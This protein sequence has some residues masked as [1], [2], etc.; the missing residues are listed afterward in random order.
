MATEVLELE[1]KS[2]IKGATKDMDGSTKSG[3]KA[4]DAEAELNSNIELQIKFLAEQQTELSRLQRIQDSIPKGAFYAGQSKLNESIEEVTK[5]IRDEKEG[6]KK[7]QKEQKAANKVIRDATAAKKK[8]TNQTIRGIQHF[9]IMGVSIRQLKHMVRSIRPAFK[10]MFGTIKSGIAATGI[11]L[12]I[13]AFGSLVVWL[14]KSESGAKV[15]S[16]AFEAVGNVINAVTDAIV[17][18][19]DGIASF[20]GMASD[21][22]SAVKGVNRL[23]EATKTLGKRMD[24]L[25]VKEAKN[26]R[27]RDDYNR[28]ADDTSKSQKTRMDAA[29]KGSAIELQNIDDKIQASKDYAIVLEAERVKVNTQAKQIWQVVALRAKATQI[30]EEQVKKQQE[31]ET[32]LAKLELERYNASLAYADKQEEIRQTAKEARDEKINDEKEIAKQLEEIQNELDFRELETAREVE[33]AKLLIAKEAAEQELEDSTASEE[34]KNAALLLIEEKYQ[35]DLAVIDDKAWEKKIADNDKW[36]KKQIADKEK[37]DAKQKKLD[38]D[39]ETEKQKSIAMGFDA[40]S[41]LAKE[42]SGIA[43]GIAVARTVYNTQQAI[44]NAMATVPAPW[45]LAQSVATGVMGAAAIQ[46]ILSTNPE[47]GGG[48]GGGAPVVATP[49]AP[50]M[51]SGAFE[52]TGG[53]A[54]EPARA[55]VVSDDITANQDKLAIIRRRATI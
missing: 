13:L 36:N 22:S 31:Q 50:E 26:Q 3:G 55:Y 34:T 28:T 35:S 23:E 12:L 53:Q 51:M 18:A 4:Y 29:D 41:S 21:S 11:G 9:Q 49:P 20:F 15:L 25:A 43:K 40:A 1:V 45:N 6:L 39:Y 7:L 54:V 17:F 30:V 44:M 46:K 38:D 33:E 5:S 27:A 10:L 37:T 2:N 8:D 16:A 24:E 48:G 32:E 42:G 14:K 19:G 52:L 47:G